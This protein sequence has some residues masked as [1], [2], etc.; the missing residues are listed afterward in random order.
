MNDKN[1][2]RMN[3]AFA[4]LFVSGLGF[5]SLNSCEKSGC[6]EKNISAAGGSKSHNKGQNCMNCHYSGGEG[7]GCFTAAG[8]AYDASLTTTLNGGTIQ[9]F[10]EPDGGGTLIKSVAIDAKGNFYTTES[11]DVQGL[12][13]ALKTSSGNMYYMGSALSNGQCNSCHNNSTTDRI[14]GN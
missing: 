6:H 9:F 11:F 4:A 14:S 10:T 1:E 12:Y 8:T 5:L 3:W 2:K 7:E 13:P